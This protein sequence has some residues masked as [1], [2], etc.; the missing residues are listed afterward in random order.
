MIFTSLCCPLLNTN[1]DVLIGNSLDIASVD[2][3]TDYAQ[4]FV[5]ALNFLNECKD[6]NT[7]QTPAE[8][9]SDESE[10]LTAGGGTCIF[11]ADQ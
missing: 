4:V 10:C 11:A 9:C 2:S 5:D 3:Q 6:R 1:A 8:N 7:S